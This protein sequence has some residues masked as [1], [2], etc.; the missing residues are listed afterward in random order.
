MGIDTDDGRGV[1]E[2][3]P[4]PLSCRKPLLTPD[5]Q[6]V[7]FTDFPRRRVVVVDWDGTNRRDVA[8]GFATDVRTDPE[9]GRTWVYAIT[10]PLTGE[11][12]AANR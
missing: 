11:D 5:G 10:G 12:S 1:R 8:D 6:R 3:L 2:I 4:G 9:T 7:V